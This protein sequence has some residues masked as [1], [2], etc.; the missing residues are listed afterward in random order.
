[1]NEA[2]AAPSLAFAGSTDALA[3]IMALSENERIALFT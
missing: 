2:A 1:M 3:A